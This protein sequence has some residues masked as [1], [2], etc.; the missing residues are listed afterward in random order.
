MNPSCAIALVSAMPGLSV[1]AFS[2]L[3]NGMVAGCA[4]D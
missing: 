1:F 2:A 3:E 4:A